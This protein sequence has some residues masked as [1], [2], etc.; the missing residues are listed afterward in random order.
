MDAYPPRWRRYVNRLDLLSDEWDK[1]YIN[2]ESREKLNKLS[3]DRDSLL[4]ALGLAVWHH[5]AN[6][7]EPTD[8]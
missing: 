4:L 5:M 7:A 1:A 2:G 6:Q 3:K 8:E